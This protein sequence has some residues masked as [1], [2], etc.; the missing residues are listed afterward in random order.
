LRTAL[1]KKKKKLPA[2][3]VEQLRTLRQLVEQLSFENKKL[4]KQ[5]IEAEVTAKV[6]LADTKV[7]HQSS[8][9]LEARYLATEKDLSFFR[10]QFEAET[11]LRIASETL[12]DEFVAA[13]NR[14]ANKELKDATKEAG[15]SLDKLA[16]EKDEVAA[17]VEK[18]S[19]VIE[20]HQEF[21]R[22]SSQIRGSE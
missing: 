16:A 5:A 18:Y 19:T 14:Q 10:E 13:T 22:K 21:E 4:Q 7:A 15:D 11:R 3:E 17:T 9:N 8:E 1:E 2:T 6:V 12:H 20:L